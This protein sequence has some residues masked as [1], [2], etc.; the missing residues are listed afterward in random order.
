[1]PDL[2]PVVQTCAPPAVQPGPIAL[3]PRL[4][5]AMPSHA[6]V[7]AVAI[8]PDVGAEASA[9]II[10]STAAV[11]FTA[12]NPPH[13]FP[14]RDSSSSVHFATRLLLDTLVTPAAHGLRLLTRRT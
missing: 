1:M 6:V 13:R 10:T 2:V 11:L 3:V 14:A 5:P 12:T 7:R 4:A 8:A 9:S